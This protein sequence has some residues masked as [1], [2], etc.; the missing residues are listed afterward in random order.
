[1]SVSFQ[2]P[3]TARF[4]TTYNRFF[5]LFNTPVPGAYNF[6]QVANVNA[7]VEPIFRNT[8]YLIDRISVGGNIPE[9]VYRDAINTVP[10]MTLTT[11]R[12]NQIVYKNPMPI[13]NFIDDQDVTAWIKTSKDDDYL[14][15]TVSG[16]LDQTAALVGVGQIDLYISLSIYAIESTDFAK[17]Y[18]GTLS[19]Q[20]GQEVRG[21][22]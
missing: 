21:A 11:A 18:L 1:M 5:A 10:T 3:H 7:R 9:E 6:L 15:M 17:S 4:I 16:Q 8:Y 14:Q 13:P 12:G 2:I 19:T 20:V 22:L